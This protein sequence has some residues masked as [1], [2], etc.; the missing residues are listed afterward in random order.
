VH[1]LSSAPCKYQHPAPGL[2]P[3]VRI[4]AALGRVSENVSA[5][6]DAGAACKGHHGTVGAK[7]IG[8]FSVTQNDMMLRRFLNVGTLAT[9]GQ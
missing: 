2:A 4:K 3:T 8:Y 6:L 5:V 9:T 7:W 1:P